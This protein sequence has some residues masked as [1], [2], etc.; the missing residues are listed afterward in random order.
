MKCALKIKVPV[1]ILI[2]LGVIALTA[3][4]ALADSVS[5]EDDD[6]GDIRTEITIDAGYSIFSKDEIF[7]MWLDPEWNQDD[8]PRP[9]R[10]SSYY[11]G[12]YNQDIAWSGVTFRRYFRPRY[13][14]SE[15]PFLFIPY[16]YNDRYI[17]GRL[18]Y[19]VDQQRADMDDSDSLD[20]TILESK[21]MVSSIKI[22]FE[23]PKY[24]VG[25]D[26]SVEWDTRAGH[27][28][29][30]SVSLIGGKT[31][32]LW[33][34]GA[35]LGL[36]IYGH[37]SEVHGWGENFGLE[38]FG[39]T[40]KLRR[41][42]DIEYAVGSIFWEY[43]PGPF[44]NI[45][46]GATHRKGIEIEYWE[47]EI[48]ISAKITL[49]EHWWEFSGGITGYVMDDNDLSTMSGYVSARKY[50]G[51][52]SLMT[53]AGLSGITSE[54]TSA[55]YAVTGDYV[56]GGSTMVSLSYGLSVHNIGQYVTRTPIYHTASLKVT[57]YD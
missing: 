28:R 14:N 25:G 47:W 45:R 6:T 56:F 11:E 16:N 33:K 34:V 13:R 54:S 48:P 27:N 37:R 18:G 23:K 36:D 15:Q 32:P 2:C 44:A 12:R 20:Q 46:F 55:N 43:R 40:F 41:Y 21:L 49:D 4:E 24:F 51:N 30:L 17:E 42:S 38:D 52:A 7:I 29:K 35:S 10:P 31:L 1:S 53:S 5:T 26:L 19:T 9:G 8:G 57:L 50:I 3:S 39:Y 22:V